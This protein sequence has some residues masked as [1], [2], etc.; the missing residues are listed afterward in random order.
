MIFRALTLLGQQAD[1]LYTRGTHCINRVHHR[2][3][4]RARIGTEEYLFV[5]FILEHIAD[6]CA[7]VRERNPVLP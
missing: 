7:Q 4:M 1:L 3:I 2:A 6:F 5:R